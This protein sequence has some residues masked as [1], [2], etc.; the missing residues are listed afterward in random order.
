MLLWLLHEEGLFDPL[1]DWWEDIFGDDEQ[2]FMDKRNHK[3]DKGHHRIYDNKHHKQK[4]RL[5][6]HGSQY[7]QRTSYEH[8]HEHK[9]NKHSERDSD[10]YF[11]YLHHVQ[12]EKHNHGHKKNIDIVPHNGENHA[13]HKRKT[14]RNTSKGLVKEMKLKHDEE[15]H[16]KYDKHKQ[17]MV[18]EPES[19]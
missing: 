5:P 7:R 16:E 14:E 18:D 3:F 1:Y 13:H 9:H 4:L 8:K 11:D 19:M 6:K 15:R 12:K 10:D 17:V 2:I